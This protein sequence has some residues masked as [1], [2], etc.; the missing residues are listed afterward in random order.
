M[1]GL[2]GHGVLSSL[3]T[4]LL[5]LHVPRGQLPGNL[6]TIDALLKEVFG[7]TGAKTIT[8]AIARRF[9]EKL[10]IEFNEIHNSTLTEYVEIAKRKLAQG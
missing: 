5:R 1:S 2:L 6:D 9:Y 10:G 7:L 3:Y 8:T 4:A